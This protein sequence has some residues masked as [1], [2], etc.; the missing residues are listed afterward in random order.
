MNIQYTDVPGKNITEV[1][2][3]S[4]YVNRCLSYQSQVAKVSV[5]STYSD[6]PIRPQVASQTENDVRLAA[7]CL[8]R[9]NKNASSCWHI[10]SQQ[11][12]VAG[13]INAFL[14]RPIVSK[15][16][17]PSACYSCSSFLLNWHNSPHHPQQGRQMS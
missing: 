14:W 12:V 10:A 4:Q 17:S 5:S 7:T 15:N 13:K 16:N 1:Q 9:N 8:V 2:R 11:S 6:L 3:T